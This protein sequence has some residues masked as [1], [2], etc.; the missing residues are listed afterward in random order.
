[1]RFTST[2]YALHT[3][4]YTLNKSM[5]FIKY[6][7]FTYL[8]IQHSSPI[9]PEILKKFQQLFPYALHYSI[10]S[11]DYNGLAK[12]EKLNTVKIL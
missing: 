3:K 8:L 1:M 10:D 9:L 7:N 11:N 6:S 5:R 12:I 4:S 2:K